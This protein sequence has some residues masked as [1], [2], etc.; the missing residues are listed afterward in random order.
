[1]DPPICFPPCLDCFKS[2]RASEQAVC[3]TANTLKSCQ[4]MIQKLS[5]ITS[6]EF[7][8]RQK[9]EMRNKTISILFL[10]DIFWSI[11]KISKGFT[12][13][14]TE[15]WPLNSRETSVSDRY[16]V[17]QTFI[18][19]LIPTSV[20]FLQYE[21]PLRLNIIMNKR[22]QVGVRVASENLW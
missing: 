10:P 20:P 4:I 15:E 16:I 12:Y 14:K 22:F 6:R 8:L 21:L 2:N 13:V 7:T 5:S 19:P 9:R 11:R 17:Y 3:L 18:P 1:M